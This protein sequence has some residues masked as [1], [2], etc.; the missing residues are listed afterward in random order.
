MSKITCPSHSHLTEN[1]LS[2]SE[3]HTSISKG[4]NKLNEANYSNYFNLS[5]KQTN[6]PIM[7]MFFL[8]VSRG[9]PFFLSFYVPN[10]SFFWLKWQNS[11]LIRGN[12]SFYEKKWINWEQDL[13][14][15]W[16]MF[17]NLYKNLKQTDRHIQ[18]TNY[19]H[20][21]NI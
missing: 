19:E 3:F 5:V 15:S 20:A 9:F 4:K 1:V 8:V 17:I 18:N 7:C 14:T 16:P 12:D 10:N 6:R 11:R 13:S 2:K 21:Y